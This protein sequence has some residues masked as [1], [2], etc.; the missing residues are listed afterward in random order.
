MDS[1]S[2]SSVLC[3][4]PEVSLSPVWVCDNFAS[5]DDSLMFD[6]SADTSVL[7]YSPKKMENELNSSILTYS[8]IATEDDS[9]VLVY[10]P[11]ASEETDSQVVFY[12]PTPSSPKDAS[13][14]TAASITTQEDE[15]LSDSDRDVK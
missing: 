4:S 11:N 8:P 1:D 2:D 3:Y 12:S 5:F 6:E 10:T 9:S 14:L 13:Q 7:V 15:D